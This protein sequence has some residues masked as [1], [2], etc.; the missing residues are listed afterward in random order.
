MAEIVIAVGRCCANVERAERKLV[1][2]RPRPGDL[3]FCAGGL[4]LRPLPSSLFP[5]KCPPPL[6]Q[7]QVFLTQV[8]AF[9]LPACWVR[10]IPNTPRL[11]HRRH[12]C[13]L[14]CALRASLLSLLWVPRFPRRRC[15]KRLPRETISLC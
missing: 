14:A 4:P 9:I 13:L 10:S 1:Q 11:H 8:L 6:A 5:S 2:S 3:V 12:F 15:T 7:F